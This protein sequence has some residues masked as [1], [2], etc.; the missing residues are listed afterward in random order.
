MGHEG[1]AARRVLGVLRDPG[2]EPFGAQ[3][4][5]FDALAHTASVPVEVP[6][7]PEIFPRASAS[8]SSL[9]GPCSS[10]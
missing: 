10:S 6:A 3:D 2:E 1:P 5:G 7:E 9:K 4:D 8:S